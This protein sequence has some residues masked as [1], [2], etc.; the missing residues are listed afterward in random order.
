MGLVVGLAL[1]PVVLLSAPASLLKDMMEKNGRSFV[2][3]RRLATFVLIG[4][5][6]AWLMSGCQ[7]Q[8]L[9]QQEV[10]ATPA[11]TAKPVPTATATPALA[12]AATETPA[13]SPT[14]TPS[15]AEAEVTDPA[16]TTEPTAAA[17][18]R[19]VPPQEAITLPPSF[20]ISVFEA[21][22]SGP[23]MM[24]VGPDGVLYLAER[25]A[26]RIVR[27]PDDN[28]DGVADKVMV[29]ADGLSAPSSIAFHNDGSL[30]VGET[31]R[32]LRLSDP[33]GEG[34]FQEREVIVDGLP[35]GGHN[36]RTVLFGP[37]HEFLYVSIGSS[38]N[39][40]IEEDERR[41]TIMRYRPDGSEET[42]YATG[43][44]N[45]VGI[46]FRP[47][48]NEL[49]ATNNGRDWLGDNQPPETI[50]I[51]EQGDDAG[52]PTC[53]AA[54][55]LDPDVGEEGDCEGVLEPVVEMQAH[56]APLGL[57]FYTGERFPKAYRGDLFVAF[58][59][60]WNRSVPTG[61]K[62]VRVPLDNGQAGAVEDFAAGWLRDDGSQWGRPVDVVTGA[63]GALYV[64]DDGEG[65][66]YRIFFSGE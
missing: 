40:C 51:V 33:D 1:S 44:R 8:K 28:D 20:G 37:D 7:V 19:I 5:S 12:L 25:G 42:I 3:T 61:Y 30:Y 59:G 57:G 29:V 58:H 6:A 15:A 9:F 60:S 13:I 31:T 4:L 14:S 2:N 62:V 16:P 10:A 50:Y 52:W 11:P 66:I 46:T 34:R 48:T 49:W 47:G 27:L 35:S 41:A 45:A 22:L 38:C 43:L 23:R 18:T 54:R 39:V 56:S 26:N 55:I 17:A 63:D 36:T 21:G 64:S 53:H 24:A 65:T 32:I